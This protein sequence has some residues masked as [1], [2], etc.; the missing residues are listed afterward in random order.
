MQRLNR[1]YSGIMP[2]EY[3]NKKSRHASCAHLLSQYSIGRNL[4]LVS[5]SSAEL[6]SVSVSHLKIQNTKL[7]LQPAKFSSHFQ[8][9]HPTPS[10]IL[11]VRTLSPFTQAFPIFKASASVPAARSAFPFSRF[12]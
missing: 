7:Y 12:I 5:C 1:F 10:F 9:V 3:S 11:R 6:T 4:S 2:P 8:S